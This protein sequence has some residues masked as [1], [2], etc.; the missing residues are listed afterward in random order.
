MQFRQDQIDAGWFEKKIKPS[1]AGK[2]CTNEKTVPAIK[3]GYEFEYSYADKDGN[4]VATVSV[5]KSDCGF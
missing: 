1:I 4:H 3:A 2:V 5:V